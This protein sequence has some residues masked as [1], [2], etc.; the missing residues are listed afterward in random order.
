RVLSPAGPG[1]RHAAEERGDGERR[2]PE[3]SRGDRL[4]HRLVRPQRRASDADAPRPGR[5]EPH[6]TADERRKREHDGGVERHHGTRTANVPATTIS[7][8]CP[9]PSVSFV[10]ATV[11]DLRHIFEE[12]NRLEKTE[13]EQVVYRRFD[14]AY[15]VP[16]ALGL[17]ALAVGFVEAT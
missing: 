16:L 13:V 1:E 2:G 4:S 10:E 5:G 9:S 14:E 11:D 8:A 12:I 7:S 17:V 3:A 6:G 15:R